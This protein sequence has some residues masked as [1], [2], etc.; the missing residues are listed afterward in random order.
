VIRESD[1]QRRLLRTLKQH[2]ALKDAVIFKFNDQFTRGIPD[3]LISLNGVCTWLELKVWPN[4]PTKIQA[5]FIKRLQRAHVVTLHKDR[6]IY[7]WPP[8]EKMAPVMN[9][10]TFPEAVK[11]IVRRCAA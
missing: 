9:D 2:P 6:F 3:I 10:W 5:Y 4:T 1:L 11:E 7:I 8:H